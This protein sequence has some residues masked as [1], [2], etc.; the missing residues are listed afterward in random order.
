MVTIINLIYYIHH[1]L[2]KTFDGVK[3]VY[4]IDRE[5]RMRIEIAERM[6]IE[7]AKHGPVYAIGG[8][9][10]YLCFVFV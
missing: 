5:I 9:G 6:R 3:L 10:I 8:R 1:Q 4:L 2:V 7:I